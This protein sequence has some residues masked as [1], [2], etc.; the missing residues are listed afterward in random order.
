MTGVQTCALPI[1]GVPD[2]L[3][4]L[5]E[6]SVMGLVFDKNGQLWVGTDGKGL[7][8]FSPEKKTIGYL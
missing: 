4:R 8:V 6:K 7:N 3:E 1:S 5:T 2:Q